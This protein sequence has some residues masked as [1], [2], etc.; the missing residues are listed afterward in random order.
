[1]TTSTTMT[2]TAATATIPIKWTLSATCLPKKNCVYLMENDYV[3]C[4]LSQSKAHFYF[5]KWVSIVLRSRKM[6]VRWK[7]VKK[8]LW[9][10]LHPK[11]AGGCMCARDGWNCQLLMNSFIPLLVM[12]VTT[13]FPMLRSVLLCSF[14]LII[15]LH[16]YLY[17]VL[18]RCVVY[19]SF[20]SHAK[21]NSR[22]SSSSSSVSVIQTSLK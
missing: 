2:T 1:M 21:Q 16:S 18:P 20:I 12:V 8:N 6:S 7:D 15:T 9:S 5:H 19:T 3:M 11:R 22:N 17:S 13:F 14:V 4:F 10:W